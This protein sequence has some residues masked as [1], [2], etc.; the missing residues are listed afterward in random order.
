MQTIVA[1]TTKPPA[2]PFISINVKERKRQ[3]SASSPV[4][5][6]SRLNPSQDVNRTDQAPPNP[7]RP[8]SDRRQSVAVSGYLG[9]QT[10]PRKR[11]NDRGPNFFHTVRKNTIS[12][13]LDP[14]E[15]PCC[16]G[17]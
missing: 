13:V 11:K 2:Y 3:K 5:Q 8:A 12:C 17:S 14:P 6:R 9:N 4:N 7:S 15:T 1:E 10:N 16:A